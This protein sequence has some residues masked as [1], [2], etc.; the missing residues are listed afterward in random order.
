MADFRLQVFYTVAKRLSFTKAAAELF[1]TQPAVTKHINELEQQYKAKLFERRGNRIALT[2]AG[3]L[4]LQYTEKIFELYNDASFEINAL[5]SHREGLLK[6]GASTT[7]SQYIAAPLLAKFR[8]KFPDVQLSLITANTEHIEHNLINKDIEIGIIEGY[9][10][11]PEITYTPFLKD[12]LVL[13]CSTKHP[14]ANRSLLK[15]DEL[16]QIRFVMREHG[17]GTQDVIEHALKNAG[18]N[19]GSLQVEIRLGSTESIKSYLLNAPCMAFMSVYAVAEEVKNGQLKIIDVD[20]L[21]IDRSFYIISLKG[22]ITGLAELFY[23][24]CTHYNIK[25]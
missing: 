23:N 21:S 13:V 3:E 16:Q 14:L 7:M 24:F 4:L 12:E 1:I 6:L 8:N 22:K 15:L 11:N 19:I 18:I 25:L 5:N 2:K 10:K 20:G 17:S 9:A